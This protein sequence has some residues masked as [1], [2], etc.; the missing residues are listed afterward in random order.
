MAIQTVLVTAEQLRAAFGYEDWTPSQEDVA[1]LKDAAKSFSDHLFDDRG[2]APPEQTLEDDEVQVFPD[3]APPTPSMM[4]PARPVAQPS[5]PA[6][7]VPRPRTQS[8]RPNT[9]DATRTTN[10]QVHVDQPTQVTN[11]NVAIPTIWRYALNNESPCQIQ[12][13]N[14]KKTTNGSEDFTSCTTSSTARG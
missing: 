9:P 5:T 6:L 1:A 8:P 2:P 4:V 7:P 10:I 13:T 14:V 11:Q 12:N 3:A